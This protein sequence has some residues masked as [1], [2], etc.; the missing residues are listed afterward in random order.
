MIKYDI[1]LN[2]GEK[3]RK[4]KKDDTWIRF[5]NCAFKRFYRPFNTDKEIDDKI[6]KMMK[7]LREL[8][9]MKTG[10]H[11]LINKRLDLVQDIA[12]D[13]QLINQKE[14]EYAFSRRFVKQFNDSKDPK[15]ISNKQLLEEYSNHKRKALNHIKE[16]Q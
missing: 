14:V 7:A 15:V 6:K 4:K 9:K 8:R 11:H 16:A 13:L 12:F 1:D 10:R 2:K 5:S 3:M